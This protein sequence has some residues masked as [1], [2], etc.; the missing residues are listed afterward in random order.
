[1]DTAEGFRGQ[2]ARTGN[3]CCVAQTARQIAT[4]AVK[5]Y[6][7]T[8]T[9][10]LV[11]STHHQQVPRASSWMSSAAA[12]AQPLRPPAP[13]HPSRP[14]HLHAR[15][16][17]HPH[18]QH[19][20]AARG[21][22]DPLSHQARLLTP[23]AVSSCT[24]PIPPPCLSL[25]HLHPC[26]SLFPSTPYIHRWSRTPAS[27]PAPAARGG[28]SGGRTLSASDLAAFKIADLA[29]IGRKKGVSGG[30]DATRQSLTDALIK[31]GVSTAG[32]GLVF[33]FEER[34]LGALCLSVCL[35]LFVAR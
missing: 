34:C 6:T 3:R 19:P 22:Y 28:S 17:P 20:Q 5:V 8:S 33:L 10:P 14:P 31:A 25:T 11:L 16:T 13:Q 1:V 24:Q 30:R 27:S 26:T 9:C 4:H 35:R 21:A 12:G 15:A 32:E 2:R 7:H 29:E 23:S 18:L